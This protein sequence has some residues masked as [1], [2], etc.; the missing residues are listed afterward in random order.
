MRCLLAGEL[1]CTAMLQQYSSTTKWPV[2]TRMC[3]ARGQRVVLLVTVQRLLTCCR[4]LFLCATAVL[5][6]EITIRPIRSAGRFRISDPPIFSSMLTSTRFDAT[7]LSAV[8]SCA[9]TAAAVVPASSQHQPKVTVVAV[10]WHTRASKPAACCAYGSGVAP[11]AA[12][13]AGATSAA[14]TSA[15]AGR[16]RPAAG[17]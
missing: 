16:S 5:P 13:G 3:N 4:S 15:P 14:V 8:S 1:V 7:S 17:C 6:N 9:S 2:S 11:R 10:A 12:G